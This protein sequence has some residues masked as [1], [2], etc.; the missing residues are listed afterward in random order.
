MQFHLHQRDTTWEI[1]GSGVTFEEEQ[2]SQEVEGY[3]L[4]PNDV[5]SYGY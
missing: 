4:L 5:M 3:Y 1:F 2:F